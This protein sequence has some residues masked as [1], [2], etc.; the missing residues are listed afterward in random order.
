M[1]FSQAASVI[2]SSSGQQ[3][4]RVEKVEAAMQDVELAMN[5]GVEGT[6]QLN[7]E[8][9]RLEQLGRTLKDLVR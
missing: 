4:A 3:F 9:K 6:R 2:F 5:S 1:D 8:A 7:E